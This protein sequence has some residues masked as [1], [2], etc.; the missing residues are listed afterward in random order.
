MLADFEQTMRLAAEESNRRDHR[1]LGTEHALLGLLRTSNARAVGILRSRGLTVEAVEAELGRLEEEGVVPRRDG[2]RELLRS[3]G[4]DIDEVLAR[5]DRSFGRATVDEAT[6]RVTRR[7]WLRR[8]RRDL[9]PLAKPVLVKRA[10]ELAERHAETAGREQAAIDDVLVG[11]LR[12]A[13]D[14]LGTQLSRRGRRS[15]LQLDLAPGNPAPVR[16]IVE[17]R[18]LTLEQLDSELTAHDQSGGS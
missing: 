12:D 8:G 6:C 4:I 9:A 3:L 15:L 14:P 17:A 11:I 13:Q 18:G 5:L 7:P 10:L 16:L 1:Y 2:G